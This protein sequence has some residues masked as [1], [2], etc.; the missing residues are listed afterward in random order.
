MEKKHRLHHPPHIFH[1]ETVYFL[2][3]AIYKK[4]PLLQS[5]ELKWQ[6]LGVIEN[7][8][9]QFAWEFLHWVILDN[10]YHLLAKSANGNDFPD[11]MRKIHSVSGF[12]IKQAT[13][14]ERPVWWN[15]WDYCPRDEVDYFKR[16]NYLFNNPIKHGYVTGLND[17]PFSS[18]HRYL[19]E[20]GRER[21]VRQFKKY[22]GYQELD[23]V[24][25]DF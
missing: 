4:R 7:T 15:Y 14:A 6:L 21:L 12:Y 3:A 9:N 5:V 1:D 24:E 18:F 13:Q 22:G 17:Y 23:F 11:I 2:T 25:D 8:L 16:L 20:Q 10:H 19:A